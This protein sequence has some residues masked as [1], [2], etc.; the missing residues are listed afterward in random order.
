MRTKEELAEKIQELLKRG[1]ALI[2]DGDLSSIKST[3]A[4]N[5]ALKEINGKIEALMWAQEMLGDL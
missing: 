2:D 1:R 5:D 3:R 4:M